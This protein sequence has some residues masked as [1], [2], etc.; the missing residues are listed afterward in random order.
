MAFCSVCQNIFDNVDGT[1]PH[2]G[3]EYQGAGGPDR[4]D[5]DLFQEAMERI[6]A[7]QIMDAKGL[8]KQAIRKD[9]AKGQYHFYLGSVLYATEDYR[10][11]YDAW[12]KADRLLPGKDRIHKCLVAARQKMAKEQENKRKK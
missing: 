11:A 4:T 2:C 5:D 7:R 8:L 12:Q 1:C 9:G 6:R 3:A 10:G